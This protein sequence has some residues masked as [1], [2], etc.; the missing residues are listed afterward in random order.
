MISGKGICSLELKLGFETSL[1]GEN[2]ITHLP[3]P[4]RRVYLVS[5]AGA[6]SFCACE[7]LE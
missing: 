1:H 6:V 3:L 2:E 7:I 5:A 4:G